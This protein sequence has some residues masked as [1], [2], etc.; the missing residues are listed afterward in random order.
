MPIPWLFIGAGAVA[1]TAGI[2]KTVK[3][4]IDN[5]N[6]KELNEAANNRIESAKGKLDKTRKACG[7]ALDEL[8]QEKLFVLNHSIKEFL[9]SFEK[10]K[11]VDFRETQGINE[12]SKFHIDKKS[13]EEL[14]EMESFAASFLEGSVAGAMGGAL[15]AFGAYGAAKTFAH[16]STGI[17]IKALKG[18]A[19]K[20]ATLAFFGGGSL[21]AGGL[22]MAGGAA[23]LGGLVAGPAL[24]VMG[25]ITGA[26]ADKNLENAYAN[27]AK[28]HEI[29][30]QLNAGSEQCIAIRRRTYMF[31]D[32]LARLDAYFYPLIYLMENVIEQEGTDYSKFS[33]ESKK[34]IA[35]VASVAVTI[36][37]VLDTALLTENGSLTIESERIAQEILEDLNK[38]KD[39]A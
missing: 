5:H 1:A 4:G 38:K 15:T 23:V 35:S 7:V 22:G 39:V 21:A 30:E 19:A 31:Y 25:F 11:N 36:K 10:L 9:N 32:L 12:L 13:F 18:I 17:A 20:N 29:S 16:A 24:L 6:A 33:I 14:K 26:Q 28:S 37:A 3:A 27:T 2:G 8:G 34:I